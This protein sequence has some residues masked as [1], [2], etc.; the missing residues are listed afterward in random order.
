MSNQVSNQESHLNTLRFSLP[1][2]L[3]SMVH[4]MKL[5]GNDL[6]VYVDE[7]NTESVSERFTEMGLEVVERQYRV[8]VSGPSEHF[9]THFGSYE[10]EVRSENVFTVVAKDRAQYDELLAMEV[11]G[12]RIRPFRQRFANVRTEES[13][14]T[15]A[16]APT[17]ARQH[18]RRERVPDAEE[19]QWTQ[20][21]RT[22]RSEHQGDR[23]YQ[24]SDRQGDRQYQRSDRQGDRQYQRSDRQGDRQGERQT[25]RSDRQGDRQGERQTQRSDRQG[26]P[27]G[28]RRSN[29]RTNQA[30]V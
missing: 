15:S 30:A 29:Q 9:A 26:Q 12:F 10:H 21:S 4:S 20:V 24:R 2:E 1:S 28:Q 17:S 13:N 11:D 3:Q 23:Q 7:S 22:K 18:S 19:G 14:Q 27:Q 25:Q 6:L 5:L 8:H 16:P